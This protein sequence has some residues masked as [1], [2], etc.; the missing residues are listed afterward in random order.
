MAIIEESCESGGLTDVPGFASSGVAC[1]IRPKHPQRKD[2]A[3]IFTKSPAVAAGVFTRHSLPAAPVRVCR[4][5]LQVST[6]FHGIVVNSGNANSATGQRG[7]RDAR[8]MQSLAARSCGASPLS[9]L[10]CS[11][12]RIGRPLPMDQIKQGILS[13][14]DALSYTSP[15]GLEAAEAILTSDTRT[16]CK[17]VHIKAPEGSVTVSGIA[18]GAGMIEPNMATMLAFLATDAVVTSSYLQNTLERVTRT[19]FNAITIDGDMSTN[20]TVL[21]LANGESGVK[22]AGRNDLSEVFQDAVW[23]VCSSLAEKMVA[24]GERISKVVEVIVEGARKA[25]HAEAVARHIGNSLLVKT[26]WYGN[27]PNWGRLFYAVGA[28]GVTVDEELL[29]IAYQPVGGRS[30]LAF[31]KGKIFQRNLARWK[32]IVSEPRFT[33][34]IN[35][36]QGSKSFR[37]LAT[38]LTEGY[39]EFNKSE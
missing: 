30:V 25:D 36:N 39:V 2:L 32:E 31:S 21:C 16:K 11:T 4:E 1:G 12:G 20:D 23:M 28:A 13:A 17:T 37:M 14:R 6:H 3:L 7:L 5:T 34:R 24:D 9:F 26:S 29:E 10:V 18:K 15:A 33:I 19:S 22:I 38:D 35:L 27:D 8:T